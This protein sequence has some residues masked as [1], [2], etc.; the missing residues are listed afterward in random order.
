MAAFLLGVNYWPR[1][2]AMA[3][4]S[5][6]E[7]SRIDE[8]FARMAE[9]GLGVVRFFLSW[10][11]FQPAPDALEPTALSRLDAV[12][13]C[14]GRHRLRAIPTLFTGHMSGVNW[15]PPWTLD[16]T[17]PSG[18]FRTIASGR[19][20]PYGA[21]DIYAGPL[22]DAQRFAVREIGAR[23][24]DRETILTWDLGNE[25][26]NLRVPASARG[27][28]D[29][30]VRL[31]EDLLASSNRPVTGGIHGEDLTIERNIRPSSICAPW[32][33][34]TMHGYPAYSA[35]A[36]D[37]R[38]PEVVP[39]LAALTASF[40]RKRVLFSEF[41]NPACPPK[42]PRDGA[43]ACL[44]EDEMAAY[45]REVL[46]RLHVRGA[47][48]ALWWCWTDYAPE[49]AQTPPFD[50]APHELRFGI[51]RAEGS[52]KPVA[53][54]LAAFAS[55]R[56]DVVDERDFVAI[57]EDAYYARLPDSTQATYRSY[58]AQHEGVPR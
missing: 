41:G 15:L 16:A 19:E 32:E 13:D 44:D 50:R 42:R 1:D 58:C 35:F 2:A 25:F 6:F 54:A 17:V 28:A 9:L 38:D 31:S 7:P 4:W 3:M 12:L 26:S 37:K 29:W 5:R 8:D 11:A 52:E 47:L 49:L 18:R 40:S 39:Y 21:G 57:E 20:T 46:D 23:C 53:R 24:R 55:E 51:V 14:A 30:S 45:A 27:A 43:I 56:R 34:A 36:R 22:L 48:G 33:M 10:E